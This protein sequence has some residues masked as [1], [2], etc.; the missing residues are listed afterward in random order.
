MDSARLEE[1]ECRPS[2]EGGTSESGMAA[3]SEDVGEP[4]TLLLP[5][6]PRP[7]E[8]RRPAILWRPN[9]DGPDPCLG[10]GQG[11]CTQAAAGPPAQLVWSAR[12]PCSLLQRRLRPGRSDP[13]HVVRGILLPRLRDVSRGRPRVWMTGVGRRECACASFIEVEPSRSGLIPEPFASVA[14]TAGWTFDL[15]HYLGVLMKSALP[16]C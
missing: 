15:R 13:P 14:L 12:L 11:P 3:D 2:E 10:Y 7:L 16:P 5:Y 4:A 8:A 6:T 9:Q 1:S